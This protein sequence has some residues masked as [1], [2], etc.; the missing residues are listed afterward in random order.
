VAD[1]GLVGPEVYT[2]FGAL[3]MKK[4]TTLGIPNCG[5]ILIFIYGPSQI[6]GRGQ[7]K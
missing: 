4:N 2:I 6:L 3:F 5:E 1:P 7:C